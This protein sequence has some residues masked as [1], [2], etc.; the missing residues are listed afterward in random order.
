MGRI[1]VVDDE[2]LVRSSVERILR[3]AGHVVTTAPSGPAALE[4]ATRRFFD[5]ALVDLHLGAMSGI[6]LLQE[7]RGIQ[8]GC[9][10]ILISAAFDKQE[11]IDGVNR[12]AVR[13]VLEKPVRNQ[14]LL[15]TI[16]ETLGLARSGAIDEDGS[17]DQRQLIECFEEDHLRLAIQPIVAAKD[18]ADVF[19]YEA[20]L[21]SSHATMRSPG[22]IIGAAERNGMLIPL[23][24]AVA[25][26]AFGWLERLPPAIKLFVNLHPAELG[27]PELLRGRWAPAAA[28]AERIV[29]EITERSR[30][31]DFESWRQ[32]TT[33]LRDLGFGI[34]VDDLGAGY[35]SLSVLAELKPE[36]IKVDMS[37][38]RGVDSDLHKRRLVQLLSE[39]STTTEA[40]LIAEGVETEPEAQA[41]RG[42]NAELLQGYLFGK[43]EFEPI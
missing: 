12:A 21:R 5:V 40:R 24:D 7:L 41:L 4:L 16:E 26:L 39:F 17:E 30:V 36:F 20:L 31:L 10:A 35:S 19:A 29:V 22:A 32:S 1:L 9:V 25:S 15:D 8:P 13:R 27:H 28:H 14:I 42:C 18:P 38:V 33:A 37:I 3:R 23:A 11:I 6:D 43:P 34:A 2:P